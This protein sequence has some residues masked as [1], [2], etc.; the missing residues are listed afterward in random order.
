MPITCEE[1]FGDDVDQCI[2]VLI[3]V[4]A[5]RTRRCLMN[6]LEVWPKG[7][8]T[9]T[10]LG[11][12]PN[13]QRLIRLLNAQRLSYLKELEILGNVLQAALAQRGDSAQLLLAQLQQESAWQVGKRECP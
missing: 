12:W 5:S 10:S 6:I 7:K 13:V 8:L 3:G 9:M 11:G 2:I 4:V 1:T